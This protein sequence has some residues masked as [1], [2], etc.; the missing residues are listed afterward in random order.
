MTAGELIRILNT[1]DSDLPIV[2]AKGE[3]NFY[4]Q[5]FNDL[6]GKNIYLETVVKNPNE[7]G[8]KDYI[9][10]EE[11]NRKYIRALVLS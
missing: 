7:Y 9:R 10:H 6:L 2:I 11:N 3:Y 1:V 4:A 8:E 5:E